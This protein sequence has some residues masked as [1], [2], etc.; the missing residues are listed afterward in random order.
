MLCE[1]LI[2]P[3]GFCAARQLINWRV[4]FVKGDDFFNGNFWQYFAETPNAA[5]V[6]RIKR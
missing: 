6:G 1:E 5:P 2:H 4:A 3:S